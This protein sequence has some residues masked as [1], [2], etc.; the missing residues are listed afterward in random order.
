MQRHT[1]RRAPAERRPTTVSHISMP[2]SSPMKVQYQALWSDR[3]TMIKIGE[4]RPENDKT[5]FVL[6]TSVTGV[7]TGERVRLW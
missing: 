5:G 3:F 6:A 2:P 1:R 4:H 7:S